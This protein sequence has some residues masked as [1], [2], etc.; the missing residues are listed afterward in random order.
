MIIGIANQIVGSKL[1]TGGDVLSFEV[2]KR[3]HN[4]ELV[5]LAPLSI[6]EYIESSLD[7]AHIYVTDRRNSGFLTN[8]ASGINTFYRYIVR[9]FFSII[10]LEKNINKIDTIYLTGDF[11]CNTFPA[12]YIKIRNKN[13]KI[14]LN[15]YHRNP[16]PK[17]R[18]SNIYLLSLVS[19][20][21]QTFS[22]LLIRKHVFKAFVLSDIGSEELRKLHYDKDKIIVS[23]GGSDDR[24]LKVKDLNQD[25]LIE[26]KNSSKKILMVGRLSRTKGIFDLPKIISN[27][28][29]DN[30]DWELNIAGIGHKNDIQLFKDQLKK[31]NIYD[32]VNILGYVSEEEKW[33]LL[34]SSKIF[35]LTSYEEGFSIITQEALMARCRVV[36]YNLSSLYSLF[37]SYDI[38]FIEKFNKVAFSEEIDELLNKPF[39]SYTNNMKVQS[40]DELAVKHLSEI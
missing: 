36:A 16:L 8:V 25:R 27:L 19:R 34:I 12:F 14:L 24:F 38:H 20:I 15:F 37:H 33:E 39:P 28:S 26:I 5:I 9:I 23:G 35:I 7:N 1:F 32:K 18:K 40:W 11:I 22:L 21:L 31:Y 6:K 17:Q 29:Q 2:L 13:I 4:K 30:A 10:F 3:I